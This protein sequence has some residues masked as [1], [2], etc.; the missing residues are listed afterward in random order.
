MRPFTFVVTVEVERTAG[1][2]ATRDEIEDWLRDSLA[3]ADPGEYVADGG[4]EYQVTTWD[5]GAS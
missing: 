3:D 2:F 1:P 5:V 4:G